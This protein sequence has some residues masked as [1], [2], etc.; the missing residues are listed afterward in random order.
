[1]LAEAEAAH[2]EETSPGRKNKK[3]QN[4]YTRRWAAEAA[5]YFLSA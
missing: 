1:V 5:I 3:N 4:V 2:E